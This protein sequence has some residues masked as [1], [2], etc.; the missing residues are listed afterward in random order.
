MI[1]LTKIPFVVSPRD[2]YEIDLDLIHGDGD[3]YETVTIHCQDEAEF[4]K[5]MD[6]LKNMPTPTSEGNKDY[7]DWCC[8]NFGDSIPHDCYY[9]HDKSA[10]VDSFGGFYWDLEGAKHHAAVFEP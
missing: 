8:N 10:T 5:M 9:G 1:R 3:K 7:E 4:L 6:A 2:K